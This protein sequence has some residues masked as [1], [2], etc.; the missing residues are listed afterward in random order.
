MKRRILWQRMQ[1]KHGEK[2][3]MKWL[4]GIAALG[5]IVFIHEVGH[6]A[7]AKLCGVKVESFSLGYGPALLHKSVRGT[8]YRLSLF[9]LGGYCGMKG[10]SDFTSAME[11]GS[12]TIEKTEGS[13]YSIHPL[14][15]ALIG[16]AGPF[17]NIL[18]AAIFLTVVAL[19]GYSYKSYSPKVKMAD[20]VFQGVHSAAKD[21]GLKSGDV[22]K[23]ID[24]KAVIS[25][26]D[27]VMNVSMRP[28][29]VINV[30]VDRDGRVLTMP[31]HTDTDKGQG[32]IGVTVFSNE[33]LTFEESAMDVK[34]ALVYGV[35][36]TLSML[37][38]TFKAIGL[39]F[40]GLDI[41]TSVS[42]TIQITDMLGSAAMEGFREGTREGIANILDL[43]AV[44][45][46]SL[47][48]MN[49]LPVP[50]LDGGLVLF[51]LIAFFKR[52]E[53]KPRYQYRAQIIGFVIIA[54]LLAVSISSDVSY[55]IAKKGTL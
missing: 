50:V 36:E 39:L 43:M 8:D 1:L 31:I 5:I 7:A 53:V 10:E 49:L 2:I 55:Y 37:R 14:L 52:R 45:S 20:E 17:F 29:E 18:F 40:K 48:V 51:A 6:F 44:I 38:I 28:N 3:K 13:L 30:T 12:D 42:G 33:L 34:S 21:A 4:Y 19:A 24:D 27:I 35:K 23:A 41:R 26:A 9:P 15:R 16:V 11:K 22:I 25:F 46:V 32:K 47:F 54:L